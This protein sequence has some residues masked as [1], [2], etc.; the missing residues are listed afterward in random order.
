[1]AAPAADPAPAQ[2]NVNISIRVQSPGDDGP[3]IQQNEAASSA[4]FDRME[5]HLKH[6]LDVKLEELKKEVAKPPLTPSLA[7]IHRAVTKPAPVRKRVT[8]AAPK[9]ALTHPTVHVMPAAQPLPKATPPP[10]P[11][12][13]AAHKARADHQNNP[14]K[15]PPA[16]ENQAMSAGSGGTS[17]PPPAV[18]AVLLAAACFTASMLLTALWDAHRRRRSRL[19]ASRLERPG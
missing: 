9:P 16:S 15:L 19:F 17:T 4:D 11:A 12:H 1:V 3:S 7:P 8:H 5:R 14:F 10:R 13:R 18:T 2:S 6:E